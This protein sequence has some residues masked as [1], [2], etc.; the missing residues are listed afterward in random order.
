MKT[1][2]L[3][4]LVLLAGCGRLGDQGSMINAG[5]AINEQILDDGTR[6]VVARTETSVSV[7]C[8]FHE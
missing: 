5:Y 8:N 7:D 3:A 6:C 4:A 2:L 1:I